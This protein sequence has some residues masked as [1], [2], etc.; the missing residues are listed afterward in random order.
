MHEQTYLSGL[1]AVVKSH[2]N[3]PSSMCWVLWVCLLKYLALRGFLSRISRRW[4]LISPNQAQCNPGLQLGSH[5]YFIE[6]NMLKPCS[7]LSFEVCCP[8]YPFCTLSHMLHGLLRFLRS[9]QLARFIKHISCTVLHIGYYE[10]TPVFYRR[11]VLD[12]IGVARRTS[13]TRTQN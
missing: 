7:N 10:S 9:S 4:W 3:M 6:I 5:N 1:V 2:A 8:Q 12:Y 13:I 11:H